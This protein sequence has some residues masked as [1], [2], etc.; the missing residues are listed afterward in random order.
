MRDRT[1]QQAPTTPPSPCCTRA[2]SEQQH[3][4]AGQAQRGL[5]VHLGHSVEGNAEQQHGAGGRRTAQEGQQDGAHDKVAHVCD[6]G[7]HGGQAESWE[8]E[9]DEKSFEGFATLCFSLAA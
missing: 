8:N 3:A 4:E 9:E 5:L 1:Q 7:P 2:E 6:A